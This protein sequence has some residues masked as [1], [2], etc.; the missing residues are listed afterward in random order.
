MNIIP[1]QSPDF[2]IRAVEIDGEPWFV[3]KDVAEA[4]GY[5]DTEAMTRRLDKDEIQNRQFVGFGNRGATLIN[6]SGLYSAILGSTKP[7]AKRFKKWV[8]SDVL[9]SIRK[10]GG[11]QAK[12]SAP[13]LSPLKQTVEA[14]KLFSACFR[15]MRQIGL[16]KNAAAISAN[17]STR[18][19]AGIDLL[20]L[21]GNTHLVAENQQSLYYTPTELGQQM[22]DGEGAALSGHGVNVLLAAAGLQ[23]RVAERWQP[24]QAGRDF[25]RVLDTGKAHAS[26]S[27]I[28]QLKWSAHV[29]P[30]LQT[31][32]RHISTPLPA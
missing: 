2:S 16:D 7:E 25:V 26:G 24:L 13:V 14:T 15:T 31:V 32:Q 18:N 9:P 28:Q 20:A 4:L 1:F 5:T 6:E 22:D 12:Q 27:P 21:T 23:H 17:Q 8:T 29:L 30:M 19:V 11:Y 10:T 3:G